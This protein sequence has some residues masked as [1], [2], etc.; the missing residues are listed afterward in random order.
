MSVERKILDASG[1]V[2]SQLIKRSAL[3]HL[4]R[5]NAFKRDIVPAAGRIRL[6]FV[7]AAGY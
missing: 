6:V 5:E 7:L 4:M 2:V 3:A 1:S